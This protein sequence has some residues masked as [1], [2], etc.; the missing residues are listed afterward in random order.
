MF[1][2]D[3]H[4]PKKPRGFKIKTKDCLDISQHA[5]AQMPGNCWAGKPAIVPADVPCGI[6]SAAAA[7]LLSS[8]LAGLAETPPVHRIWSSGFRHSQLISSK[9]YVA[10][11]LAQLRLIAEDCA[12]FH[13]KLAQIPPLAKLSSATSA[14]QENFPTSRFAHGMLHG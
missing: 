10:A 4:P 14:F 6:A 11:M 13:R 9:L 7:G 3:A 1:A 12:V 2:A 5:A 8:G